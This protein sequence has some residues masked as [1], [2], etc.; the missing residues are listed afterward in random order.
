MDI[1]PGT[2]SMEQKKSSEDGK[3]IKTEPS[4]ISKL[5]VE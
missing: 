1:D 5:A 2:A 4:N 3:M